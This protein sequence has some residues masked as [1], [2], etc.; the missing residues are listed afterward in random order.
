M[1]DIEGTAYK[2]GTALGLAYLVTRLSQASPIGRLASIAVGSGMT[3]AAA[4]DFNVNSWSQ[5]KRALQSAWQSEANYKQDLQ[6]MTKHFGTFVFDTAFSSIGGGAGAGIARFNRPKMVLSHSHDHIEERQ[7]AR[8]PAK[9]EPIAASRKTGS[10]SNRESDSAAAAGVKSGADSHDP[11]TAL[12]VGPGDFSFIGPLPDTSFRNLTAPVSRLSTRLVRLPY[13][14]FDEVRQLR[15]DAPAKIANSDQ[16]ERWSNIQ[17]ESLVVYQAH[18]HQ[19]PIM[20]E[21]GYDAQL[22]LLR[23]LHKRAEQP[24]PA[25][26]GLSDADKKSLEASLSGPMA[27]SLGQ[28]LLGERASAELPIIKARVALENHPLKDRLMPEHIAQFLDELPDPRYI[29]S[30]KLSPDD[31]YVLEPQWFKGGNP[32]RRALAATDHGRMIFFSKSRANDPTDIRHEWFHAVDD[33][34]PIIYYS[35]ADKLEASSK[36]I[37]SYAKKRSGEDMA[38][39]GG[40][41]LL[42]ADGNAFIEWSGNAPIRMMLL[43]DALRKVMQRAQNIPQELRSRHW[44]RFQQRVDFIESHVKPVALFRLIDH[45]TTGSREEKASAITLLAQ[46][47]GKEHIRFL[48]KAAAKATV[49]AELRKQAVS[50]AMHLSSGGSYGKELDYLTSLSRSDNQHLATAARD[51]LLERYP[52][53]GPAIL[54]EIDAS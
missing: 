33:R 15:K 26:D 45:L 20:V 10:K 32:V 50:A 5:V 13:R 2:Q 41:A 4:W 36:H 1:N 53:R 28:Q 18:G 40:M 46:F 11:P 17:R 35:L 34:A 16:L 24:T 48:E 23:R 27:N 6:V 9:E 30:I 12:K 21:K 31:G 39:H 29:R 43:G 38:E 51:V 42:G 7:H 49:D 22:R 47:G 54:Q 25:F 8:Q 14:E 19:I 52:H 3:A 44:D 37:T